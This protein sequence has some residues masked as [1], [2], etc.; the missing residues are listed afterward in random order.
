MPKSSAA[1]PCLGM[2]LVHQAAARRWSGWVASFYFRFNKQHTVQ[3]WR[4]SGSTQ[5][6]VLHMVLRSMHP[7]HAQ[8]T[9]CLEHDFA[10]AHISRFVHFWVCERMQTKVQDMLQSIYKAPRL[11]PGAASKLHG[12]ESFTFLTTGCC[13]KRGRSRLTAPKEHIAAL[14]ALQPHRKLPMELQVSSWFVVASEL[15]VTVLLVLSFWFCRMDSSRRWS[16]RFVRPV[17]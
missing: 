1:L 4:S 16:C 3:D 8:L 6:L 2:S 13:D 9:C 10:D 14:L 7:W 12:F 17:A 5:R 15:S 11:F